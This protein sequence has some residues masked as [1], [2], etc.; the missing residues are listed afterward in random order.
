[1]QNWLPTRFKTQKAPERGTAMGPG[2]PPEPQT[3]PLLLPFVGTVRR[4]FC[5]KLPA[6]AVDYEM[7]MGARSRQEA[8]THHARRVTCSFAAVRLDADRKQ[9]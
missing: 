5:G 6:F 2:K 1:M 8:S 9:A 7:C 3:H 4:G